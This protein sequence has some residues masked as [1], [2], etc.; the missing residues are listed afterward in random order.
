[1]PVIRPSAKGGQASTKGIAG[2]GMASLQHVQTA[3]TKQKI[4][5]TSVTAARGR[6]AIGVSNGSR[7]GGYRYGR[8]GPFLTSIADGGY[9]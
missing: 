8:S 2:Q 9:A 4:S 3:H 1:M 6:A 5:H 7:N